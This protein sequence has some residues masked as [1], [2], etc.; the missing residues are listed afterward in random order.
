MS[1]V[2]GILN[3]GIN[4]RFVK[5]L[6]LL[7]TNTSLKVNDLGDYDQMNPT[8]PECLPWDDF[9]HGEG[10]GGEDPQILVSHHKQVPLHWV[11]PPKKL[12]LG[13][14]MYSVV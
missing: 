2:C 9:I 14:E 5:T 12:A 13:N 3:L 11:V 7:K 10:A 8:L 6:L 4:L 1:P